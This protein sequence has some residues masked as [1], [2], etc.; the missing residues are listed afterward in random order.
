MIVPLFKPWLIS[1]VRS[2]A[3]RTVFGTR[4]FKAGALGA[5]EE[6]H[7]RPLGWPL[8]ANKKDNQFQVPDSSQKTFMTQEPNGWF[9]LFAL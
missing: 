4:P 7:G 9:S 3:M 1:P 2:A 6:S 8:K 5:C